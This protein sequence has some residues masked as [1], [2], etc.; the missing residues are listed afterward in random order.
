[1]GKGGRAFIINEAHGL[2]KDTIRQL[3]VVLERLP[4]HVVVIF[5]T[6][7]EGE[8]QLFEGQIDAHPLLSR[9]IEIELNDDLDEAFARRAQQI[10]QTESLD[11]AAFDDYL[12]LARRC[13]GNL[14][15]MLQEVESG[16]MVTGEPVEVRQV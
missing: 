4:D 11:G 5:T 3:L 12:G 9:C 8:G 16:A 10:A 2:R 15:A 1:M 14:R 13:Q 6:T 7:C